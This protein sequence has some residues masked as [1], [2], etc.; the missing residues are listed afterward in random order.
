MSKRYVRWEIVWLAKNLLYRMILWY[1]GLWW[2]LPVIIVWLLTLSI[3]VTIHVI[4]HIFI[5]VNILVIMLIIASFTCTVII[6]LRDIRILTIN[7]SLILKVAIWVLVYTHV[8]L[9]EL[10]LIK[11]G[12]F[13]DTLSAFSILSILNQLSS[14]TRAAVI[15]CLTIFEEWIICYQSW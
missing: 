10:V 15:K 12:L 11:L 13:I 5:Y 7:K 3:I 9:L 8:I 4:L 2:I 1:L 6:I 14:V